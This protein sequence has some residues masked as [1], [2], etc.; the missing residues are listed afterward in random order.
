[1]YE[2]EVTAALNQSQELEFSGVCEYYGVVPQQEFI[3]EFEKVEIEY[4]AS[5]SAVR[6]SGV[7]INAGD[8]TAELYAPMLFGFT[9][10]GQYVGSIS[11]RDAPQTIVPGDYFEF[12]MNHGFDSYHS[13]EPFNGAGQDAIF[14]LAMAPPIY[15]SLNCVG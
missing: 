3:W 15:V 8:T 11:S 4:D 6:A 9:V 13:N 10:D 1:V 5:R 7:A 14:V 12:E 2:D